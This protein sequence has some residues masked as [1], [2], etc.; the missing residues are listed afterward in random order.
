MVKRAYYGNKVDLWSLGCIIYTLLSG[1]LPFDDDNRKILF[2]MIRLGA[3]SFDVPIWSEVSND[4]KDLVSKLLVT[5]PDK[6]FSAKDSLGHPWLSEDGDLLKTRKLNKTA[7]NL[8]EFNSKRKQ[9][10]DDDVRAVTQFFGPMYYK[11]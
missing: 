10:A 7:E 5:D 11:L 2:R 4:A 9:Q 1:Y 3:Y 8:S 6:R